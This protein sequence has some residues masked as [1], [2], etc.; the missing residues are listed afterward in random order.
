M[1]GDAE[2][3]FVFLQSAGDG[4]KTLVIPAQ[5]S[6]YQ[7][8]AQQVARL[9]G[10]KNTIC[11]LALADMPNVKLSDVRILTFTIKQINFC[12]FYVG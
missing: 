3:P 9:G 7:W 1:N 12:Y 5:S 6:S 4:C 11:I 10:Q 8:D 2:F